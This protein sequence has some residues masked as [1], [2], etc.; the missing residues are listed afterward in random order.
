MLGRFVHSSIAL[1]KIPSLKKAS[2]QSNAVEHWYGVHISK[3]SIKH[4]YPNILA[5]MTGHMQQRNAQ[6]LI[7]LTCIPPIWNITTLN[8]RGGR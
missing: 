7:L 4:G 6:H 2:L 8:G 3:S 1:H 5:A